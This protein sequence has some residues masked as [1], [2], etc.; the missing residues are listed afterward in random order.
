MF[1]LI[2]FNKSFKIAYMQQNLIT[3]STYKITVEYKIHTAK[4]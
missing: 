2:F 3:F 1:L 4:V